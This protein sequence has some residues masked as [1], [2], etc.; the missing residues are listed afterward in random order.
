MTDS[1]T[2]KFSTGAFIDKQPDKI[3]TYPME[4]EL[5]NNTIADPELPQHPTQID[6]K[7]LF[8]N[9]LKFWID[10]GSELKL[11]LDEAVQKVKF[12]EKAIKSYNKAFKK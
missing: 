10:K 6:E 11:Q 4:T 8:Q 7:T 1:G 12:Y 2:Y 5:P 9:K 3:K